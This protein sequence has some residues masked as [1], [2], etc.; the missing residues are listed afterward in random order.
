MRMVPAFLVLSSMLCLPACAA[1][2]KG[3]IPEQALASLERRAEQAPTRSQCYAYAQAVHEAVEY[4]AREYAAGN[5]EQASQMLERSQEFT[6]RIRARLKGDAKKLKETEILLRRAM[7]RLTDVL[8]SG[9]YEDQ[10]LV[11]DTLAQLSQAQNEVLFQL[12]S[13]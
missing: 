5:L 8:H 7:Y 4:S 13:K 10:H 6:R 3:E 11:E 12:F 9:S 1:S 2:S